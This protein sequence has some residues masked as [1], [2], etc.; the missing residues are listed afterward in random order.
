MFGV[1]TRQRFLQKWECCHSE[2]DGRDSVDSQMDWVGRK[3]KVHIY[4]MHWNE[5]SRV[6]VIRNTPLNINISHLLES[7]FGHW[8]SR[9]LSYEVRPRN[10]NTSHFHICRTKTLGKKDTKAEG[11]LGRERSG[12]RGQEKQWGENMNKEF[13][14]CT[15]QYYREAHYLME[16]IYAN[17]ERKNYRFDA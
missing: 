2:N 3:D 6:K 16:L 13:H 1:V 12:K 4:I 17:K 14:M 15:W 5:K 10:T 7:K 11:R 9:S 8:E